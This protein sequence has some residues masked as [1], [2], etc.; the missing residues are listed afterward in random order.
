[1][2]IKPGFWGFGAVSPP[3]H[4]HPFCSAAA[5]QCG[6]VIVPTLDAESMQFRRAKIAQ[7]LANNKHNGQVRGTPARRPASYYREKQAAKRL[8]AAGNDDPTEL[9]VTPESESV[10]EAEKHGVHSGDV[11]NFNH[12]YPTP[13]LM[14]RAS[15]PHAFYYTHHRRHLLWWCCADHSLGVVVRYHGSGQPIYG[16]LPNYYEQRGVERADDTFIA[17]EEAY[18]LASPTAAREESMFFGDQ[19]LPP[20]GPGE[21]PVSMS[22][23][24]EEFYDNPA[25]QAQSGLAIPKR[26][27]NL[28]CLVVVAWL[29]LHGTTVSTF[30]LQQTCPPLVRVSFPRACPC[31]SGSTSSGRPPS[32]T[33]MWQP[34]WQTIRS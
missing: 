23:S 12:G 31:R 6:P 32:T 4:T 3:T 15:S 18:P 33:T 14:C 19:E 25:D 5:L 2:L 24:Q 29:I 30:P 17:A 10:T 34:D 22:F 8:S 27:A 9:P 7:G 28:V 1:M 11:N 21:R 16:N 26:P 13:F 20:A